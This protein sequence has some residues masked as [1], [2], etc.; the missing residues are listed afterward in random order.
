MELRRSLVILTSETNLRRLS[1]SAGVSLSGRCDLILF[2]SA[3]ASRWRNS[4]AP[5]GLMEMPKTWGLGSGL[6]FCAKQGIARER[7]MARAMASR[8]EI[9]LWLL[10]APCLLRGILAVPPE[11]WL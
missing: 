11:E 5:S 3:W 7:S 9:I 2:N 1:T 8:L 6:G 10:G 4:I